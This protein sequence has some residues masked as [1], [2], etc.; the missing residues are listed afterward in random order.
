MSAIRSDRGFVLRTPLLPLETFTCWQSAS[1]PRAFLAELAA[2]PQVREALFVASPSLCEGIEKWRVDPDSPS[3]QQVELSLARYVARMAGRSTPFGLFSAVSAG[4]LGADTSLELAPIADYRRRTRLD[5]DYLF[6]LID[7]ISKQPDARARLRYRPN[8]SLYTVAGRLRYV[9]A[10]LV[11]KERSYHLVSIDPTPYLA[12]TLERARRGAKLA[13][14]A[15]GLAADD[16]EVAIAEAIAYVDELVAAQVLV[17]ELGITVT[18]SEPIDTVIAQLTAAQL[19]EP[20]R[21]LRGARDEIARIDEHGVGN[22]T[23][24]Y[25]AIAEQLRPLPAQVE[26]ARLFQVDTIKPATAVVGRKLVAE[27]ARTIEWLRKIQKPPRQPTLDQFRTA[28][29]ERYESRAVP[30]VEVLDEESGI[31]FEAASGP[32]SEGAPLLAGVRFPGAPVN[33]QTPWGAFERHM[34]RRLLAALDTGANEISLGDD[35]LEAL[36][37]PQ[38]PALPDAHHVEIRLQGGAAPTILIESASGPSGACMLGRFCHASS[39]IDQIVREHLRAEEAQ[40]PDAVFAEVVHLNEGRI[41]NIVCRPVL[42]DHEIPFLGIS[43]APAAHQIPVD[44]LL[45]SVRGNRIVL[46]SRKL[47]REV[48][49]R[50]TTA[51]NFRLRSLGIYRFLCAL[52]HS[53]AIS[54]SWSSLASH[55][56]LPRVRIGDVVVARATW[57]LSASDLE[58]LTKT[59]REMNTKR[60]H[61]I[62]LADRRARIADAVSELRTHLRLP[63][64]L[65]IADYDNELPIDL[66]N[67]LL[68]QVFADELSGLTQATLYEQFPTPD[69]SPVRGPDGTFANELVLLFVRPP[70]TQPD[71]PIARTPRSARVQRSFPPGSSWLY[72]KLYTGTSTTDRLLR[73]AIGPLARRAIEQGDA[74]HWFFIRYAD[75]HNHVRVR[76]AGDPARL[77]SRVL[78][79]LA[80]AIEPLRVDGAV[81]K[82]QLDSYDREIERYGGDRGIE[83]VEQLFWIDSEAV[84]G[85][86]ELLDGDAGADARWRLALRGSESL[87]ATL[88]FDADTRYRIFADARDALG[89]DFR[90]GA[91]FYAPIG[92]RFK[93]ERSALEALFVPDPARDAEHDLSP[94]LELLAQRDQRLAPIAH[95]LRARDSVGELAPSLRDIA[96]SLVH[97]HVNRLLHASHR[98][99]ELVL[100]DLLRRLHEGRR[101]RSRSVIRETT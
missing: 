56:Y 90:V 27:V 13:D 62:P 46:T 69:A 101:A 50:L 95:E 47:G 38:P 86:V 73:E 59:V 8:S 83:L 61:T 71:Q 57:N 3:G 17:P 60:A 84:L 58:P 40:R 16:P 87:L 77:T 7:E 49:P 74:T 44:D 68:A 21:V 42:R 4:Q 24:A 82:I 33:E 39:E 22:D 98:A 94:G 20:A 79:A 23:A 93:T 67:P 65:V 6:A 52:Q 91:D 41:G 72:A 15:T 45:V 31:G 88:G 55:P 99:Q 14:L 18:G 12:A 80:D 51:H 70:P 89:R 96:W 92:E 43:G 66:D 1:D 30:L 29:S 54:W 53:S 64:F 25:R 11:G 81:W 75:P 48:I 2:R 28:F 5:N 85:I 100:Y 26:L 9:E 36:R 10:R 78:P 32:G 37:T 34:Q 35:D 97:M 63:R 19:D 76:F